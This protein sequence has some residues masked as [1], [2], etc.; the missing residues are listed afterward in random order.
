MK[1]QIISKIKNHQLL[2]TGINFSFA[3]T[4]NTFC[5]LIVGLLNMRWLGPELLGI[6][7]SLTIIN[8]YLPFTQLGIQ[9]GL[10]LRLP[11]LLGAN[12]NE[13]AHQQVQTGLAY[14]IFLSA[15]FFVVALI[16]VV[17]LILKGTDPKITCGVIAI[18]IMAIMSCYQLHYIATF[19]SAGAFDKLT[20]IYLIE[21]VTS[22]ALIYFIYKYQY[23]GLVI[24]QAAQ[25]TIHV[26]LLHHYAPYKTTKPKFYRQS[27]IELLKPGLFMVY[28][29][30]IVGV[31]RS[32]PR[33][34]LLKFGGV[35][36]VGLF[37]PALTVGTCMNLIPDQ[38]GTFLHP[39]LGYKYG[40]TKCARDMWRYFKVLTILAPLVMLPITIVGWF[41]MPYVL[42]YVFPKYISSLEPIRIMLIGFLFS[43]AYLSRGFLMSIKAYKQL[44]ILELLDLAIFAA[45]P[46]ALIKLSSLNL[47]NSVAL[48]LSIGYFVT[49]FINIFAVKHTIFLEKFN[50][51][52]VKLD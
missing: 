23:Y 18:S 50:N 13:K 5:A 45:V 26:L 29:N 38:L 9:S 46:F 10:N 36:S 12:E 40:Q 34:I 19:R 31:I 33:V 14:A 24:Y 37:N 44:V 7:Q 17:I 16:A 20:K 25:S 52:E 22:I 32:L 51:P 6:W 15:V 27:F 3:S 48:G 8:S 49:Y 43:T 30:Q 11:V 1:L 42:E 47:L 28:H 4:L 21:C 41:A 39:Q 35:V 2:R